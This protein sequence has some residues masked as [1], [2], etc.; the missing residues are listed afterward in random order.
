MKQHELIPPKGAN[1]PRKRVGRGYGSGHGKTAG[2]GTKGQKSRSGGGI[3]RGFEGGQ[4]QLIHRLPFKRGFTNVLKKEYQLLSL[5][6]L[7]D[8]DP[9]QELTP[10]SLV[11]LGLVSHKKSATKPF[12]V[13]LL[14][15][16]EVTAPFRIRV[17]KASAS[18]K[19]KIAA[20]GGA[21]EELEPADPG[22]ETASVAEA[23]SEETAPV[24]G[25]AEPAEG[26]EENA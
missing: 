21:V 14:G 26:S 5:R 17:H 24:E 8:L 4:S 10:E 2:R 9:S 18:A 19:A 3:S 12:R 7:Q 11:E 23:V 16:G 1:R 22:E 6:D 25:A 20:A 15:D 13:K